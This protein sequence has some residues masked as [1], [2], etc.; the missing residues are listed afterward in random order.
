MLELKL[1]DFN[2]D[3]SDSELYELFLNGS[4]L[5]TAEVSSYGSHLKD[6]PYASIDFKTYALF[7]SIASCRFLDIPEKITFINIELGTKLILQSKLIKFYGEARIKTPRSYHYP[8]ELDSSPRPYP[9]DD[10]VYFMFYLDIENWKSQSS[11]QE[12]INEIKATFTA[13]DTHVYF[14]GSEDYGF[15]IIFRV[16]SL[17]LQIGA[18]MSRYTAIV[19]EL[20]DKVEETLVSRSRP[21][22]I[23]ASFNFPKEVAISCEQYLLYFVQFLQDLGVDA[24]SELKHEAGQVL[25]TV[26]PTNEQHALNAIRIALDVYLSMP[27]SPVSKP[28]S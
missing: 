21:E 20:L 28:E 5:E 14:H 19:R 8:P 23:V 22:S 7:N 1:R 15:N 24:T 26:T 10:T 18:E 13:P 3:L 4:R 11:P 12:Y 25:F 27:S 16:P 9:E 17:E 6:G 2:P